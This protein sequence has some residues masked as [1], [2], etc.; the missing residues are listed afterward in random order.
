MY[1]SCSNIASDY[2][3]KG[4]KKHNIGDYEAAIYYYDKAIFFNDDLKSA[5]I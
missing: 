2:N 3:S 5:R 1:T 4:V